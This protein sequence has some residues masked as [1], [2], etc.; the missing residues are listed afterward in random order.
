[1]PQFADRSD[2]ALDAKLDVRYATTGIVPAPVFAERVLVKLDDDINRGNLD[3]GH[4]PVPVFADRTKIQLDGVVER[5][6]AATGIVPVPVFAERQLV[7][8]DHKLETRHGKTGIVPIPHFADRKLPKLEPEVANANSGAPIPQFADRS[9]ELD[10]IATALLAGIANRNLPVPEFTLT[11][12]G[13]LQS[14]SWI[15]GLSTQKRSKAVDCLAKAIYYEARSEKLIG[16][17]AVAQVILNRVESRKYPNSVCAVV[18]QNAHKHNRC[19]F[20]FACDGATDQPP[21]TQVWRNSIQLAAI[22]LVGTKSDHDMAYPSPLES[23]APAL[24]R[25]THYHTTYVA[26]SWGKRLRF[27]G[28]IGGHIFYISSRAWS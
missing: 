28:R 14:H 6:D 11:R 12:P 16:R 20:S 26:P 17:A 15:A 9:T 27:A 18:F 2:I 21:N 3:A 25:A 5:V 13:D 19:Q 10:R 8:I 22:V 4:V 7:A 23:L 24:K 1:M